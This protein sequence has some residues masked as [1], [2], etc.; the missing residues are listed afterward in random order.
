MGALEPAP[1]QSAGERSATV[2]GRHQRLAFVGTVVTLLAI[3]G[4]ICVTANRPVSR[5]HEIDP[6]EIS[7][8]AQDMPPAY[9]WSV[10]QDM[11]KGLDRRTDQQYVAALERFHVWQGVAV[12]AALVGI[13]LIASGSFL[14]KNQP[15]AAIEP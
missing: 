3:V 13:A 4:G 1:Q 9:A 12:A 7:R 10:W 6:Y 14:G 15:P 8:S 2:W 5:F 11:K